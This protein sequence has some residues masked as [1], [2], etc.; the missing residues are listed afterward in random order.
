MKMN[1]CKRKDAHD[2]TECNYE[3]KLITYEYLP[4]EDSAPME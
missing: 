1:L 4:G 2:E 3:F